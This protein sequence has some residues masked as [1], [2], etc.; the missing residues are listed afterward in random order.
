MFVGY[1]EAMQNLSFLLV[2]FLHGLAFPVLG[3]ISHNRTIF[4]STP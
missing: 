1:G 4:K 2:I 3:N